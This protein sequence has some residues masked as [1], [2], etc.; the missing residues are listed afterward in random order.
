MIRITLVVALFVCNLSLAQPHT[1]AKTLR[2]IEPDS[3]LLSVYQV[4]T[5]EMVRSEDQI[6]EKLL[7]RKKIT[8]NDLKELLNK[9]SKKSSYQSERAL[10][11]H[12][13]IRVD[14][15]RDGSM[16]GNLILSSITGNISING[17]TEDQRS[18]GNVSQKLGTYMIQF[19]EDNDML[20]QIDS[21][22]L[23]GFTKNFD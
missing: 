16:Y 15:Y 10:L 17:Q 2:S 9:A 5:K 6:T 11:T 22:D 7:E 8:N 18:Y 1:S 4:A 13:N 19:L 14:L 3:C 21:I 12:Y 20:K 23:Q